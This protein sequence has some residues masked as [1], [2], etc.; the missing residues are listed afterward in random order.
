MTNAANW[1][2]TFPIEKAEQRE[3]GVYLT[4]LATGPEIDAEGERMDKALIHK[5]AD[6][7]NSRGGLPLVDRLVYRDAHAP[8]GVL[9][10]LGWL[11]KAW[12]TERGHLGVE[13]RLDEDNPAA[14]FLYRAIQRGKQYGMSVAGK[15][16]DFAD[17]F[18]AE[19][20]KTV[21]TYK[22][23]VLTEISNTTRPAWTPSFGSVL[24]KAIDDAAE[25]ESAAGDS[26]VENEELQQ[27]TTT[28]EASAETEKADEQLDDAEFAA[29]AADGAAE[30][31]AEAAD[32]TTE[33]ADET[34]E[35]EDEDVEKAGRRISS[36]DRTRLLSAYATMTETMRDLGLIE[37]EGSTT[38]DSAEKADSEDE[39][40][41]LDKSADEGTDE[42]SAL[43]AQVEELV[44]SNTELTAKVAELEQRPATVVPPVIERADEAKVDDF[45]KSFDQLDPA[46]K[47]RV[48]FAAATGGK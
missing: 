1:R 26:H 32:E 35:S 14:M 39:G 48:A 18:V 7:I 36:A 41:T 12:V 20:G 24:S 28:A 34:T 47:L 45:R 21:R 2:I 4:G 3:D 8:D 19:L 37:A 25:A 9:R 23:V 43:R 15:V 30:G 6:Q 33:K 44:K 22:D 13:V 10:D 16:L 11:T 5:F 46:A 31:D 40:D 42:L 29:K 38:E 17:E 27:E